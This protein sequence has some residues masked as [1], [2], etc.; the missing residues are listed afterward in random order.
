M[1]NK[2]AKVVKKV[3]KSEENENIK[4]SIDK[5]PAKAIGYK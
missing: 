3:F 5:C 2:K 1:I 4:I